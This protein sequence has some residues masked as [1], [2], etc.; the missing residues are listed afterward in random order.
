[1]NTAKIFFG[2]VLG[3]IV[4]SIIGPVVVRVRA[5]SQTQTTGSAHVCADK[6]GV[7]RMIGLTADC[8][9]GQRSFVFKTTGA[10]GADQPKEA[11][12]GD[13]SQIDQAMLEQLNRRI[14]KLENEES[15]TPGKSKVVAPFQVVD[16]SGRT[17]FYVNDEIAELFNKAG[18]SVARI[19]ALPEGGK[20]L[21][22]STGTGL[23]SVFGAYGQDSG[24]MLYENK[25]KRLELGRRPDKGT[26]RA[27]F[28]AGGGPPVAGIGQSE[29]GTGLAFVADT[30][31]NMKA[32]MLI[33]REG[34]GRINITN[35]SDGE[36]LAEITQGEHGGGIFFLCSPSGCNPPM[37]D[38]GD[39]G[40]YG[41]VRT[42]PLGF[43]PGVGLVGAPGSFLMG[44]KQ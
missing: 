14:S 26:Y 16:R 22:R 41:L 11:K 13:T 9:A 43:N 1:M 3:C 15:S 23:E 25:T 30:A 36:S 40:G 10:L 5:Q 18:E 19:D 7:L 12:S 42:G 27:L 37:V 6:D 44:K 32:R 17:I 21:T 38:A 20:F 8:P 2:F 33:N 39:A 4:T 35:A 34:K 29:G 24:L 28:Y 31:G